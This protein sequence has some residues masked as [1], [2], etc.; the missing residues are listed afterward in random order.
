MARIS[1][2]YEA[3]VPFANA[4]RRR[5]SLPRSKGRCRLRRT[6]DGPSEAFYKELE[7]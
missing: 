4:S 2:S 1:A 3:S 6:L 7:H 5:G